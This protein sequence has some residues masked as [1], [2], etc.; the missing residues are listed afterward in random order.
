MKAQIEGGLIALRDRMARASMMIKSNAIAPEEI[1][2]LRGGLQAQYGRLGEINKSIEASEERLEKLQKTYA[3]N[4]IMRRWKEQLKPFELKIQ[5]A[6]AEIERTKDKIKLGTIKSPISGTI[7]KSHKRVGERCLS[8]DSLFSIIEEGS[9]YVTLYITQENTY[10]FKIGDE[11]EL[12]SPAGDVTCE[13]VKIGDRYEPAPASIKRFYKISEHL[14][15]VDLV[16]E[17]EYDLRYGATV[18]LPY[19]RV[20]E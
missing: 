19:W 9:I 17:E 5:H 11:V 15:P 13:V 1:V 8:T 14:L 20:E 12:Y 2:A 10:D 3:K 18:K 7:L 4:A 6:S 16:P